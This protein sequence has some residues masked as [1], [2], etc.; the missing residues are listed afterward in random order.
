MGI[1]NRGFFVNY[2]VKLKSADAPFSVTAEKFCM[3]DPE[4]VVFYA[5][6]SPDESFV[7]VQRF[8]TSNVAKIKET[9]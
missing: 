8:L 4:Y 5:R 3:D 1:M 6:P 2:S 7:E 9:P